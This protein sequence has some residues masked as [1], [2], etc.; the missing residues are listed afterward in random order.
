MLD[1]PDSWLDA[2]SLALL[3][4][5]TN[6]K[7]DM[8]ASSAGYGLVYRT[9]FKLPGDTLRPTFIEAPRLSSC[10]VFFSKDILRLSCVFLRIGRVRKPL[11]PTYAG[12][13]NVV[14]KTP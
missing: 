5:R 7:G 13:Y 2:L 4:I 14:K 8:T 11:E 1:L 6:Y 9:T 3:D 10:P 12:P